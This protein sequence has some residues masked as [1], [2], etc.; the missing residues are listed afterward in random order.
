MSYDFFKACIE[1]NGIQRHLD[2]DGCRKLGSDATH[3]LARGTLALRTL[4]LDDQDAAAAGGCQMVRNTGSYD[5][6]TH[7]YNVRGHH[8]HDDSIRKQRNRRSKVAYLP[9]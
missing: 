1:R 8:M 9:A 2:I 7:D 4:A 6:S 5:S 3:A